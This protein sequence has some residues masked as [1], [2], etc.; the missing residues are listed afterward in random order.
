VLPAVRYGAF[1]AGYELPLEALHTLFKERY[2]DPIIHHAGD[3]EIVV[4]TTTQLDSTQFYD[5]IEA[6]R[7]DEF[8]LALG[9]TIPE[10]EEKYRSYSI[11]DKPIT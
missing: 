2:V 8:V 7:N 4:L 9:V 10:P 5:Y 11:Q 6:I 3:M 1:D